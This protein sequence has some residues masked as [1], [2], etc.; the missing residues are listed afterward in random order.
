MCP[1]YLASTRFRIQSVF[2]NFHS[3]ERIQ[4]VAD[5]YAGF[6]ANVWTEGES[7]KKNCGFKQIR[8]CLD[9]AH[10]IVS[11]RRT[12]VDLQMLVLRL[13]S[14]PPRNMV[15]KIGLIY[16][17]WII[18]SVCVLLFLFGLHYWRLIV[19]VW[20]EILTF[21]SLT[22][23]GRQTRRKSDCL[24]LWQTWYWQSVNCLNRLWCQVITRKEIKELRR[25][26]Y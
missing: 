25:L 10:K 11:T 2:K 20:D 21:R 7:A 17:S 26:D 18:Q 4:K 19:T 1:H 14:P 6:I 9:G 24:V 3:G 15:R 23:P 8:I 5:S 12:A 13:Q 22:V 16:R